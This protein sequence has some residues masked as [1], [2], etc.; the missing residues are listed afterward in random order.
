MSQ[1][2]L[3][4]VEWSNTGSTFITLNN[5][6]FPEV[7]NEW[8]LP[9]EKILKTSIYSLKSHW[10]QLLNPNKKMIKKIKSSL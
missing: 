1:D 3:F 9:E 4:S 2:S 5:I 7:N 8:I 6:T 10:R